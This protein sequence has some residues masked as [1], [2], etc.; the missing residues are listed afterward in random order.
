M[1]EVEKETE[2]IVTRLRLSSIIEWGITSSVPAS[3]CHYQ[4]TATPIRN[5]K[6]KR[7]METS[8]SS[9]SASLHTHTPDWSLVPCHHHL[10][11]HQAI[12]SLLLSLQLLGRYG[13]YETRP[14]ARWTPVMARERLWFATIPQDLRLR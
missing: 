12:R 11:L 4:V 8:W 9:S 5:G 14:S 13:P 6:H 3:N 2:R 1:N 10:L 7:Q